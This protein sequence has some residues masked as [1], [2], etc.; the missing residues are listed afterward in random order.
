MWGSSLA[1]QVV[2][3]PA[4]ESVEKTRVPVFVDGAVETPELANFRFYLDYESPNGAAL[5]VGDLEIELAAGAH[6][7][8]LTYERAPGVTGML[9]ADLDGEQL[10][11][12]ELESGGGELL[13]T[14]PEVAKA[15]YRLAEDFTVAAQFTTTGKGTIFSKCRPEGKWEANAKAL[16]V[17]GGKL[18]YDVGW[19]G[20]ISGGPKVNDGKA[21]R[22]VLVGKDGGVE[23]FVDGKPAGKKASLTGPDVDGHVVKIG[24]AAKNFG[25]DWEGG[26]IENVRFWA[27]AIEGDELRAL[28][29]GKI[30]E[31]N[32]PD[33]NWG[34]TPAVETFGGAGVA[35]IPVKLSLK[36]DLKV[37]EAWAQP[38]QMAEHVALISN[39][40][41]ET[42]KVGA[43]IYNTL[44]ITC[45]GTA[46]QEGT[47][48]TALKFHE[49]E[50][51]NGNDPYRMYQT[52]KHGYGL[53]VPQLQYTAEQKYAVI[54]Y[55]RETLV[56]P[57]NKAQ[58]FDVDDAYLA[59]LPR[60]MKTIDEEVAP[61][62]AG[63]KQYEKMDFGPALMWTYQVNKGGG[64][65][66]WNIAQKGIA[67][68]LDPGAGGV[69]KGRAWM[70]YD[71]DTM[72]V[73][74]AY[75]GGKFV[76]WKGIAFDGSH[77]THTSI[78]GEPTFIT[79]DEP[80]WQNP[81]D[82]SWSDSRIVGRDGRRF[83]P[84]PR[85]WVHYKGMSYFGEQVV[86][87]YTVGEA[88]ILENPSVIEYGATPIFVR[89]LNVGMTE[90]DLVLRLPE[91]NVA[92]NAPEG[93]AIKDGELTIPA[94]ATPVKLSIYL[95]KIDQASLDGLAD[96]GGV[97][98][99]EPLTK[100]GPPRF[101]ETVITT[102]GTQ[103]DDSGP[104]AVD[105]IKTPDAGANP[106]E[107][108]MR[109]GGFDF[110]P[111]NPDRAAVCTWMGDVWLVDGVAG[112]LSKLEW[113]RICSGLFQ[114]LGLKIHE[115]EI[116]VTCR[117]Q[118]ARLHDL[119]G[120]EEID[121]VESFNNDAQVT[122]HFHEFA[123]GLQ[124][125]AEG[126]FYYA[127][128]ARHAKTALV[129]HHGTLLR[130]S[131]DGARTDIVA[132]GFRAANGV[133]L[134]P[135]G[136]WIVTDQ[137]GHWNPKNRINYVREGGF[138]GNMFGYHDVEDD[139]DSAMQQPLC[140]ITNGF[141]RS[142]AELLWATKP[143]K[144][145]PF[146]GSLLNTS[147]GYGKIYTV[148]HEV[149]DGQAQGGM[150][151]IPIPQFATGVMR[152]RFHPENG[153]LYG[154]GLFAW[155]GSRQEPGGFYRI[156]YT[157]KPAH[158]P[159]GL[160]ANKS[161]IKI[162]FSD[163]L[164]AEFVS[165][166]SNFKVKT[167]SLKRTAN[168]GSKHYDEKPLTVKSASLGD[169]GRTMTLEIPDIHTTWCMEIICTLKGPA[170]EPV[171]RVI[172]NT[173]HQLIE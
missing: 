120:D 34:S 99:L 116:Y 131:P 62:A 6:R 136:T 110:Y 92:L 9:G 11:V 81:K 2:G 139:S 31:V 42:L 54:Q 22:V 46:E 129:P 18:V 108:W 29:G 70:V 103:G 80:G 79:P 87:H 10:L 147:Y 151:E 61:A 141:D 75:S 153:Q 1:A 133:C 53:M 43:Q 173:I 162:T 106:W 156:R 66:E 89:T 63:G 169:D 150:C 57:H 134:N 98:D 163:P 132:N 144:W 168:Y 39:W 126:N 167:W 138:Y 105:E 112:D 107:S 41:D 123:M 48:P 94:S 56:K 50:F 3:F 28:R 128:S 58:L 155:A 49:G 76:D 14:T 17:R 67:V 44:C 161:G 135:D 20:A 72:R 38:L 114:P 13:Q 93:I 111:D 148:P 146:N 100:G 47:L 7:L 166:A 8:D 26:T 37:N 40:S 95:S 85:E 65:A 55:I 143:A 86:I 164:D 84:L 154:C 142:P 127:K 64:P 88:A 165:S 158:M 51:K 152:G 159:I 52:L 122:E 149:I 125:D 77:G 16:F 30:G 145:G 78:A 115:G 23:M 71:E 170:G 32:T 82:G 36:G 117:D 140:W 74:A 68:R 171:Q 101:G 83:G 21:H 124:T 130:V 33:L 97:A 73:A 35:G 96:A 45:H 4:A 5:R 109:L 59:S 104:F 118:I 102:E 91:T 137:E 172:N 25:F 12:L 60:G 69:S 121:F 15:D 90:H 119:N 24:Q 157:G 19:V 160:E 113:R 27:R